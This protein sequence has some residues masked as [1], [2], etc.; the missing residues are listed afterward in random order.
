MLTE[1]Q[2]EVRQHGIGAS[3]AGAVLG[4]D[5]YRTPLDVYRLKINPEGQD[6]Y[7]QSEP[8]YWGN[9]LED[10]VRM[11]YVKR[12][13]NNVQPGGDTII[14][15]H[16]P[17]M[18]CHLDAVSV[19]ANRIVECKTASAY[20]AGEWGDPGTGE[21][22]DSYKIQCHHQ[23]IMTN[24]KC[25]DV[26]V[27]LGGNTF[28]IYTVHYDQKLADIIIG[29]ESDFWYKHVVPRV[30][31]NP[32]TLGDLDV[33]YAKE[34]GS[35]A[36]AD[37]LA[38]DAL[39]DR[40]D[41]DERIKMLNAAKN[42]A[43]MKIK[44]AMGNASLLTDEYGKPLATWKNQSTRRLDQKTLKEKQPDIVRTYTKTTQSRVLRIK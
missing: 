44:G 22:P 2:L 15:E 31:P 39:I 29:K 42:T 41:I 4:V 13:G 36:I 26:P 3:D 27:L 17:F 38:I 14:S 10:I 9:V 35:T 40:H 7:E 30:P 16:Y 6:N 20:V 24:Y 18:L 34:D 5:K 11:E 23:M 32:I 28:R 25:V 37:E 43:N 1:K 19:E 33:L 21:I 8:A 12:T